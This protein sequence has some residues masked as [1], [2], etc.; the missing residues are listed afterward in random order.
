M[1]TTILAALAVCLAMPALAHATFE[2][3]EAAAGTTYKA[4][5]R[6]PHGCDGQA[7]QKLAVDIPEGVF[8]VK[9]MPKAGW[10]LE[11]VTG[12]YAKAYDNHGKEVTSGVRQIIWT[13]ELPDEFYDEFVFRGTIA[14]D[15]APGTVL[16][17]PATQTCADGS[18]SWVEIPQKG[19]EKP[20]HPAPGV[21][22]SA[23]EAHTH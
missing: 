16:Y 9:P 3:P 13:G 15:L 17:F 21:T 19:G 11:T 23:G 4:V 10:T 14:P 20:A 8:A 18:V 12:D 22:V 5:L 6:V 1:K 7:T 2:T